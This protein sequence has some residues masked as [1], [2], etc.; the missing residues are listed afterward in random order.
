MTMGAVAG[1]RNPKEGKSCLLA[2]FDDTS[3]HVLSLD[4]IKKIFLMRN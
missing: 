1:K 3:M 4:V 2:A